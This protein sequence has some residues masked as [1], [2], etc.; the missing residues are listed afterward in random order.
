M[1]GNV[2]SKTCALR[3]P[4]AFSARTNDIRAENAVSVDGKSGSWSL[5]KIVDCAGMAFNPCVIDDPRGRFLVR[6]TTQLRTYRMHI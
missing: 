6:A 3:A 4:T 5:F 1:K 2:R